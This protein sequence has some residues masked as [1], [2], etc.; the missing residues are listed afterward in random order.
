MANAP[1]EG[2]QHRKI[3]TRSVVIAAIVIVVVFG[4]FLL[5]GS[6]S[7]R[8]QRRQLAARA[9]QAALADSIPRVSVEIVSRAAG[10]GELMLPGTL[11]ASQSTDVYARASGYV[12]A[13]YADIGARVQA[14]QLLARIEAPD[15]DQQLAQARNEVVTAR[16][17]RQ[18]NA[19]NLDRWKVLFHDSTVT[20][21]EL[22][23]YQ[24]NFDAS[25]ATEAA[26]ENNVRR[27]EALVGYE[28]VTAP[29]TGVVTARNVEDGVFVTAAGA[30]S[31]PQASG[32]GGNTVVG[33]SSVTALFTVARTDTVRVYIGVPQSYA[34]AV[35]VGMAAPIT[36]QE[37]IGRSFAGRVARTA[38][39]IDAASRT[40]LTEVDAVNTNHVLLPG[41]YAE[42]HL[43]FEQ[44]I[45][46]VLLPATALIFRTSAAQAAVVGPDSVVHIHNLQIGRDFGTAMEVDSGLAD[47]D[48]VVV[49]PP[50][51]LVDGR[52]VRPRSDSTGQQGQQGQQQGLASNGAGKGQQGQ[53]G[54][55]PKQ[56][57]AKSLAANAGGGYRP[58]P[59]MQEGF[60]G[61]PVSRPAA[62]L[63]RT[64]ARDTTPPH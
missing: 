45:P 46:P 59:E 8:A 5:L 61:S 49:N 23:T 38:S 18:L 34:P 32:A 58:P 43:R 57:G 48:I 39:S 27:L 22:D 16:S 11:Q 29:F 51:N 3:S 36:A 52:H 26:A 20:K 6:C 37:L 64:A 30:T 7:R 25:V 35:H 13:W 4:I 50:D 19:V 17:T 56:G 24:T 54:Q 15:L 53:A 44:P 40:L 42:V 12:A 10:D 21:Q 14:G 33:S 1:S 60:P 63:P 2:H 28:R 41:M 62:A 47:G 9:Q 31:A 55:N